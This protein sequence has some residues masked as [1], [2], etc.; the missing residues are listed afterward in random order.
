MRA[1]RVL[2]AFSA[3]LLFLGLSPR[4]FA[5]ELCT[6]M[7]QLGAQAREEFRAID[8]GP[9]RAGSMTHATTFVVPGASRC[10]IRRPAGK[11]AAYWC[12]WPSAPAALQQQTLTFGAKVAACVGA[13]PTWDREET[14]VYAFVEPR[15]LQY[16]VSGELIGDGAEI[17]LSVSLDD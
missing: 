1:H 7:R 17:S 4:A 13:Q 3:A 14:S 5:Q 8:A 9:S 10:W 11:A 15:G 16:Y 2:L 12:E 6:A